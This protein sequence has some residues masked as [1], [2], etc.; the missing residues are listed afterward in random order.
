MASGKQNMI[1]FVDGIKVHVY[2]YVLYKHLQ[3]LVVTLH[4]VT[5]MQIVI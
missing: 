1:M 5:F 2:N 3:V 4:L